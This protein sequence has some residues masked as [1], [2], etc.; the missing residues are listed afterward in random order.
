MGE[1]KGYVVSMRV[2]L[3]AREGLGS[4]G[5]GVTG[6]CGLSNAG[7]AGLWFSARVVLTLN[8]WPLSSPRLSGLLIEKRP[9]EPAGSE[10]LAC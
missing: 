3:E 9:E 7:A 2:P 4:P 10:H 8:C 5:A 6:S 1:N